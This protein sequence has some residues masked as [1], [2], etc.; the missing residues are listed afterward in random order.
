MA[1][2]GLF[3]GKAPSYSLP[4]DVG[5]DGQ[6][7]KANA[8]GEVE[9]GTSSALAKETRV[10]NVSDGLGHN[11]NLSANTSSRWCSLSYWLLL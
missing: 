5:S 8:D 7:L 11:H 6:T 9:W 4:S 3:S 2:R 10:V 1:L